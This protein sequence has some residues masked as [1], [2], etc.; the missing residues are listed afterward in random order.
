MKVRYVGVRASSLLLSPWTQVVGTSVR[1]AIRTVTR[2]M[3]EIA[4]LL[5]HF[6]P[7][8]GAVDNTGEQREEAPK[9]QHWEGASLERFFSDQ[10]SRLTHAFEA[11]QTRLL[12]RSM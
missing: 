11:S 6:V 12:C 4:H 1:V 10:T 5:N 3:V 7:L 9:L 8:S 2:E